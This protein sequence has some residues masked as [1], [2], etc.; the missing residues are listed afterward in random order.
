MNHTE[1]GGQPQPYERVESVT[2][3]SPNPGTP[4]PFEKLIDLAE[5]KTTLTGERRVDDE[6]VDALRSAITEMR[7]YAQSLPP[8][9][10]YSGKKIDS[11]TD[12]GVRINIENGY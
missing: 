3:Y 8:K 12:K 4:S 2:N 10:H 9:H 11:Q 5:G 1:Q 6:T 7:E